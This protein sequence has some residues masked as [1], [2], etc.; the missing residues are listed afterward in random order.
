MH[1]IKQILH[2]YRVYDNIPKNFLYHYTTQEALLK[3]IDTNSIWATSILY[4]NDEKEFN[5]AMD[6]FFDKLFE[7]GPASGYYKME[8]QKTKLLKSNLVKGHIFVSSLSENEDQLSQ[9]RAYCSKSGFCIGFDPSILKDLAEQNGAELIKCVYEPEKQKMIIDEIFD[10]FWK[11]EFWEDYDLKSNKWRTKINN[12]VHTYIR[13]VS[14]IFKHDSFVEEQE[15]RLIFSKNM[16]YN[17]MI[18]KK[19]I[20]FRPGVSMLTPYVEFD[21]KNKDNVNLIKEIYVGPNPN[22]SYSIYSIQTLLKEKGIKDCDVKPS[23]CTFK[24]W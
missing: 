3:I 11:D 19:D 21:F 16:R 23:K 1:F 6:K 8:A 24:N 12:L 17:N 20:Q 5:Q 13:Y 7:E 18:N 15:W 9:W 4:L 2:K 22:M 10:M 14:P